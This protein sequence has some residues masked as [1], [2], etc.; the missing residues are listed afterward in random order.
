VVGVPLILAGE[1][2]AAFVVATAPV[3][4]AEIRAWVRDGMADYAAPK[5]V[6]LVDVLPRNAVGKTDKQALRDRLANAGS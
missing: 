3:T 1:S 4:P 6:E 2:V 5:V